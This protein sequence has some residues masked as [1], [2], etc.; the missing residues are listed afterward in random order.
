LREESF[1][2]LITNSCVSGSY[3]AVVPIACTLEPWPVSVIA[4]Q[5]ISRP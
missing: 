1:G 2:V 4:K 3:V 5:P